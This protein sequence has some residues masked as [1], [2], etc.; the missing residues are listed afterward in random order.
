M[1]HYYFKGHG[2]Q[3]AKII[4]RVFGEGY[5]RQNDETGVSIISALGDR[6][7][8]L[9]DDPEEFHAVFDVAVPTLSEHVHL[10][11]HTDEETEVEHQHFVYKG[12]SIE[13][14]LVLAEIAKKNYEQKRGTVWKNSSS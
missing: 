13:D 2:Y 14:L 6:I 11:K 7:V 4:H 3:F 12:G 9:V 5:R 1:H 8:K 10:L